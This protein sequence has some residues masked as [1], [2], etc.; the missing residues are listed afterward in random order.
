MGE[1][2]EN[3]NMGIFDKECSAILPSGCPELKQIRK[4]V[5]QAQRKMVMEKVGNTF[6]LPAWLEPPEEME[7]AGPFARQGP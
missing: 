1:S 3:G 2:V 5:Q 6:Q 4:L 7:V